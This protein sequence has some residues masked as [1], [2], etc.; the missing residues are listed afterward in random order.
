MRGPREWTRHAPTQ[1]SSRVTFPEN[2]FL[3]YICFLSKLCDKENLDE[4]QLEALTSKRNE[5]PLLQRGHRLRLHAGVCSLLH[6]TVS[7]LICITRCWGLLCLHVHSDEKH[8]C[9]WILL[10]AALLLFHLQNTRAMWRFA[11]E[12]FSESSHK[13]VL[14]LKKGRSSVLHG[15]KLYDFVSR[16]SCL[17]S[18]EHILKWQHIRCEKA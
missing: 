18:V 5:I 6:S 15:T 8:S 7:Q 4:E 10:Q 11:I 17:F 1:T 9:I 12:A 2:P 13:L 3:V 14:F 16:M